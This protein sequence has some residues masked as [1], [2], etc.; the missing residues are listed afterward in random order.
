MLAALGRRG[1]LKQTWLQIAKRLQLAVDAPAYV[2]KAKAPPE[3]GTGGRGNTGSK[4]SLVITLINRSIVASKSG[5]ERLL[6]AVVRGLVRQY[7]RSITEEF[8]RNAKSA[9]TGRG[10][11]V[12]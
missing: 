1:L 12:T 4:N 3:L 6:N 2:K 9:A 7:R 5:G 10:A 11:T 8:K